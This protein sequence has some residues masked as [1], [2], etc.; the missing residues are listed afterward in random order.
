MKEYRV[1][2]GDTL[3][4]IAQRKLGRASRWRELAVLNQLANPNLIFVGQTLRLPEAV[5]PGAAQRSQGVSGT[6]ADTGQQLPANIALARGF[7][8]IIFEQLPDVGATKLIRKVAAIPRDFSLK[9]S[10]LAGTLSPAEH[11]LNLN[12]SQSQFLSASNKPFGAPTMNG[13][14]LLLDIAKIKEAGGVIYSPADIIRD[15]E[16]FVAENPAARTQVAKLISAIKDLEGEVLIEKGAPAESVGR[17]SAAHSPYIRAAE[18]L[19]AQYRA[20]SISKA[21][22][23]EGLA[24][25]E[26]AY[27]RARLVGRVGRVLTVVAVIITVVDVAEATERSIDQKSF[28]P[29]GAEAI[30]QVGGWGGAIAGGKIGFGIGALFGIET[31]PG[32]VVTGLIGAIVFGGAGYF[33][34]DWIADRISPN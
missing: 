31:G 16:R 19:W 11:A 14:P 12:P 29:I 34:A 33:G 17:P 6:G 8:F 30:R 1:Q 25:L 9:P 18:K 24:N 27:S 7:L 20:S 5:L 22:L 23:E 3:S 26:K 21:Q 13:E 2:R 10:N 4:H 32:A 28:K 15:L